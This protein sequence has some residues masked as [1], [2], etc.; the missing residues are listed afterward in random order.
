MDDTTLT[1]GEGKFI[2]L[3]TMSEDALDTEH[4]A[5]DPS[6]DLDSWLQFDVHHLQGDFCGDWISHFEGEDKSAFR[7]LSVFL[8]LRSL[9]FG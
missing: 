3:E 9:L 6:F 8:T 4:E 5:V 1:R 7:P 2:Q